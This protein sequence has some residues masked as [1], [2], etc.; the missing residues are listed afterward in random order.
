MLIH[1]LV[2]RYTKERKYSPDSVNDILDYYQHKYI[3]GEIDLKSYKQIFAYLHR[4]GAT[5]AYEIE[6][7][8]T[9][10]YIN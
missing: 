7:T 6:E 8:Y 5:S 1:D 9:K 3:S 2:D 4:K 10:E